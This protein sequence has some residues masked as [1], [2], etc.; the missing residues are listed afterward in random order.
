MSDVLVGRK[1]VKSR[2]IGPGEGFA[3]IVPAGHLVQILTVSGKQVS[4][5]VA[6]NL[7]DPSEHLSTAVTR[8]KNGSLMLQEG[9]TIWSNLRRPMF[10]LVEDKVGRHDMLVAA[11]DPQRY[12]DDFGVEN[13]PSCRVAFSEALAEH[14]IGYNRIPDPI[15]WFMNVGIQQRGELEFRPSIA[16]RND[17]VI[18]EAKMDTII[19]VTSCPMDLNDING[20]APTDILVR[21]YR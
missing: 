13:H 7:A 14:G 19:G 2:Q 11:C 4:D 9:M 21:V 12:G 15:N 10:D 1:A 20:G 16:E 6:F 17:Y 18:L 3:V 8:V 5:F